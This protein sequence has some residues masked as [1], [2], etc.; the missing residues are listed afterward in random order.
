MKRM[1]IVP[2]AVVFSALALAHGA[3]QPTRPS[4]GTTPQQR[5]P[6][7]TTNVQSI[8]RSAPYQPAV[9]AAS[10]TGRSWPASWACSGV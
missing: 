8:N 3:T 4:G 9:P 5:Q 6:A 1:L 7:G 2:L 10:T